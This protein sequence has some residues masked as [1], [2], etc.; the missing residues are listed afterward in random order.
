MCRRF[1]A[2]TGAETTVQ[3]PPT[4][5]FDALITKYCAKVGGATPAQVKLFFDGDELPTDETLAMREME[6]DDLI[7]VHVT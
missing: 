7:D 5:T 1:A 2:G 4:C 6:D 3:V